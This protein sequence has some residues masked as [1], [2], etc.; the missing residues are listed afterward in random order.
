MALE[1]TTGRVL[2]VVALCC[3]IAAVVPLVA[4]FPLLALAVILL[5][6]ARLVP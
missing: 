2:A 3:G 1:P 5:A 6:V 4:G